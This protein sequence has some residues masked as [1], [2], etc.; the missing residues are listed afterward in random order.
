MKLSLAAWRR[1]RGLSQTEVA[2]SIGV[3][4]NTYIRWEKDPGEIK[5][6]KAI[7]LANLLSIKLD[8]I[9]LPC[10]T[11]EN[12]NITKKEVTA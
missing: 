11:T 6:E 4:V 1:A 5:Y 7:A 8:D 9:I 12:D 10:D 3:H 2:N